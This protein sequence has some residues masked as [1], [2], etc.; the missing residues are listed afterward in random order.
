MADNTEPFVGK[1]TQKAI[2]FGPDGDVLVTRVG[3]HWEPPGG[4]FEFGETLVGGLRRELREELDVDAA[5]GPPVEAGYGGWLDSETADPMVTL[6]YRCETDQRDVS[7]NHEHDDHEWV[8]PETAADRLTASL[9]ER[10]S[11]AIERA[12][13]LD[14]SEPFDAVDDPYAGTDETTAEGVLAELAAARAA[15]GPEDLELE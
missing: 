3:D 15:D 12:A 4:T 6:V 8:T 1:I 10:F 11:R 13:G 7:L 2:L 14:D 9:G 5:V